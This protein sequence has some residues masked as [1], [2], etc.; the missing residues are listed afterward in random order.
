MEFYH[1]KAVHIKIR[2]VI[3]ECFAESLEKQIEE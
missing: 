1:K 2:Y 3:R